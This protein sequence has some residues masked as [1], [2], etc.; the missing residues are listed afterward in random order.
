MSIEN[1]PEDRALL[2]ELRDM[3]N[4]TDPMP[5]ELIDRMV[6]AVA[7][8]DLSRE[9]ALLTLVEDTA[10]VRGDR[11]T[12]TL[13]FRDGSTGVLLQIADAPRAGT[14]RIDGWIDADAVEVVLEQGDD[15]RS[16]TPA[17][18]GRF[19][20][21][22]VPPGLARILMTVRT[23]DGTRTFATPQFEV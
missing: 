15:R 22:E 16:T 13:Q 11:H 2:T 3:W 12:L 14:R 6:A 23:E 9:Y 21:D 8:S 7:A 1:T 5:G 20:F 10:A 18:H 4:E 17:E 19:A